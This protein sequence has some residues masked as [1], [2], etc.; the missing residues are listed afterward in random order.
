M[1]LRVVLE[2]RSKISL[3]LDSLYITSYFSFSFSLSLACLLFIVVFYCFYSDLIK[4]FVVG[5]SST[6]L[7]SKKELEVDE[8]K[9]IRFVFMGL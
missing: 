3:W 8:N 2:F 9:S 5:V 7:S 6:V 1:L 4:V